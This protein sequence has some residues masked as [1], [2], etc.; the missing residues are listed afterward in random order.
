VD[1]FS[2]GGQVGT[3]VGIASGG[4]T[5]MGGNVASGGTVATGGIL[6][7]GGTFTP[8]GS[9][10]SGGLGTG[11][12][13]PSGGRLGTGGTSAAGG[14]TDGGAG[15]DG[16][17]VDRADAQSPDPAADGPSASIDAAE[18]GESV[19]PMLKLVAGAVGG[20]GMQDGT[21]PVAR[22]YDP[23]GVASDGNGHLF[24]AD[25]FNH[26]IRR[27]V[28]ATGAV[29]TLAG[30][31]GTVGND[32]GL[33]TGA[34]FNAPS[35]VAYD[36]VG[37]LFVADS[38]NHMIRSIDLSTGTV[39]TVAGYPKIS[40]SADGVGMSAQFYYPRGVAC[41]GLGNLFVADAFNHTIR[42]IVIA[43][44]EVTTLAGTAKA[45]GSADGTGAA[46]RFNYPGAMLCDGDG[47]LF[48]ADTRNSTLRKI[49][50]STGV[51]T[52]F[53][54]SAGSAGSVDGSGPAARLNNPVG[55]GSDGAGN[56]FFADSYNHTIRKLVIATAAVTT[57]AGAAGTLG[58]A[59]G[60]GSAARFYYPDGVASDGAGNLYVGDSTN[61]E[62]R[63]V[64]I[65]TGVVTTFAGAIEHQGSTDG[66][67]ADARFFSPLRVA[68]DGAGNL[69]VADMVNTTVRKLVIA[70]GAV[71][72][73]LGS[74]TNSGSTDGIG[75]AASFGYLMGI[76]SDGAGNLFI[77]DSSGCTIRKAVIATRAVTTFAGMAGSMGSTD[78]SGAEARFHYPS[79]LVT[80]GGGN[81]FVADT[82]NHTL[83]KIVIATGAVTTLAGSAGNSGAADGTGADARFN[84]PYGVAYD[85]AG[86]LFVADTK[87]HTL[88]K[89]TIAT[90]AVTTVAGMA[91]NPGFANGSGSNALFNYPYAVT[92]DGAGGLFVGDVDN[93]MVRR[94]IIASQ[95]VTTAV[96][97]PSNLGVVLGPLP[98]GLNTPVGLA[99]VSGQG[100]FIVD[101]VENAILVAQF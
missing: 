41:D 21:G 12:V 26:T 88:R 43:T 67:G 9:P 83:R 74:S 53:V 37:N 44:G 35:G 91:G 78:G 25:Q 60:T 16:G 29:T 59:D 66:V 55:I 50:I 36:G 68:S 57:L 99:F 10:G 3:S 76:A 8:D 27:M 11:G 17:A 30:L 1:S 7:T 70:T 46:A 38:D 64:V 69:F 80:D 86:N 2:L 34:R 93:H 40:G 94:F 28:L 39:S 58:S 96:G 6:A 31:P 77:A 45:S 92:S 62:I 98:G 73:F 4:I 87:N 22:F 49:V 100:L 85:G 81:L 97:S 75:T 65:A 20:Q 95:V 82:I 42:K 32:D 24:V 13:Q 61:N 54:G 90:G 18:A 89:V 56:L 79:D 71:T 33:G 19:G 15:T 51:V 23:L 5:A 84:S 52:T 47:N 72:T 14:A 63:K 48:V 101:Q